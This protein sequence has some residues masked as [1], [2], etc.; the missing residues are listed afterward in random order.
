MARQ[1][2][3]TYSSYLIIA[4]EM[5]FLDWSR[6]VGLYSFIIVVHVCL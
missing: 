3:V 5:F 2:Y 1:Q 4:L 6:P